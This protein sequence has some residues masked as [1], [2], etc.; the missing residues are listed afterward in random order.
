VHACENDRGIPGSGHIEWPD[1]FTALKEIGYA[2]TC[3]IESFGF[4]IPELIAPAC[5]WRDFA[6]TPESI[7]W[8]GLPFLKR[9]L[10]A[11]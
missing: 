1:V 2:G 11:S 10:A 3:S 9:T 6:P 5:I 4:R 8:E 7:A